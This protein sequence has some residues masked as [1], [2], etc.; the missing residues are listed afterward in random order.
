MKI[1]FAGAALLLLAGCA[2][3]PTT[4]LML[5]PVKGE[6]RSGLAGPISVAHVAMPAAIDRLY[7]TSATGANT[8]RVADHARWVAPLGGEAQSVLAADLA[9]R[10]PGTRVL[11]PGD[12]APK[13]GDRDVVV[14]V[15]RF[16]PMP[17]RVVLRAD[18]TITG[19]RRHHPVIASGRSRIVVSSSGTPAAA[20]GAMSQALGKLADAMVRDLGRAPRVRKTGT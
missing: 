5:A 1:R 8:I 16:L 4:Y 10:L 15:T 13:G 20:A 17:G 7:L 12:R 11:H 19:R 6:V 2:S 9:A 3:T 14:N 18:W